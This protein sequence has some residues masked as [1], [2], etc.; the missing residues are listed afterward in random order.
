[1]TLGRVGYSVGRFKFFFFFFFFFL[2]GGGEGKR[3]GARGVP[4]S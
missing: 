1:M 4:N 2:G 3:K